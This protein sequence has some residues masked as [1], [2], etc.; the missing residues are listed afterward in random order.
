MSSPSSSNPNFLPG[1]LPSFTNFNSY[2]NLN[3]FTP[4]TSST[5]ST[6]V[7]TTFFT[8][9]KSNPPNLP[10]NASI[11]YDVDSNNALTV[12]KIKCVYPLNT[13]APSKS[14]LAYKINM[15]SGES[16]F[17]SVAQNFGGGGGGGNNSQCMTNPSQLY[18]PSYMPSCMAVCNRLPNTPTSSI[19]YSCNNGGGG[20]GGGGDGPQSIM[21]IPRGGW[22]SAGMSKKLLLQSMASTPSGSNIIDST[23]P[24][25]SKQ[26][27]V[28]TSTG[29][30]VYIA[31]NNST[32]NLNTWTKL[33][34]LCK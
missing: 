34:D 12:H 19:N 29:G 7:D 20:G 10:A 30:P 3:A 31:N 4:T 24:L 21:Y 16:T 9:I 22:M 13:S 25:F 32:S 15:D 28:T 1:S 2:T 5:D 14:I 11:T 33:Q 8:M 23:S 27:N 18:T 6:T 26:I 17:K